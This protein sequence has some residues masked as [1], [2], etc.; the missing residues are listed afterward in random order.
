VVGVNA[1]A[2]VDEVET[3]ILRIDPAVERKQI[4]RLN[5]VR[6]RR[7]GAAVETALAEIRQAA[8]SP[9]QNLMPHLLEAAR[10]HASEGEI[11]QALQRVWGDYRESP[12]F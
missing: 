8:G 1:F 9:R 3:P 6:A 4:D 5:A 2:E 12:V 10:V 7:D 11:V